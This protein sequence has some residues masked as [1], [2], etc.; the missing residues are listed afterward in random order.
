[1]CVIIVLLRHIYTPF[2]FLQIYVNVFDFARI[3]PSI[4][5]LSILNA[6]NLL[7]TWCRQ[8]VFRVPLSVTNSCVYLAWTQSCNADF[9]LYRCPR[10]FIAMRRRTTRQQAGKQTCCHSPN[11]CPTCFMSYGR[12]A[13]M[14]ITQYD[15]RDAIGAVSAILGSMV[16]H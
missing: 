15:P 10:R 6:P 9:G 2:I 8:I 4:I 11:I 7:R 13:Y 16:S 1:M 12:N 3:L 5:I 14:Y